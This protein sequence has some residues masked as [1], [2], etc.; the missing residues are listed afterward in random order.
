MK[1]TQASASPRPALGLI[2]AVAV[3]VGIVIGAGIFETPSLVAANSSSAGQLLFFWILGGLISLIGA[4]CYAEL[5]TAYPNAGG[6]YFYLKHGLGRN[7]GFLFAWA[8]MLVIQTGSISLLAF[9]F[10][11]YISQI[12]SLG[13]HSSSIYAAMVIVFFT[14][15]NVIGIQ[16]GKRAQNILSAAQIIGLLAL[17]FMGFYFSNGAVSEASVVKARTSN[18]GLAM[19]FVLLSFGG[20]NEAAFISAEIHNKN[21]NIIRSLLLSLGIIT[22][23]YALVN[24]AI[25]RGLGLEKMAESQAVA[26]TLMQQ[27]SGAKGAVFI[28]ILITICALGSINATILTGA[29]SNYALGKDF[30]LFAFLGHWQLRSSAPVSAYLFQAAIA[31]LLVL[32]GSFT[33]HGFETMVEYTAPVFWFFFLLSGVALIVL[34]CKEPKLERPFK[35]P[36]YPLT[37]ILFCVFCAYLLYSSLVYTGIGATVGVLV[38]ALGVPFLFWDYR[39]AKNLNKSKSI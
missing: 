31:L 17:V 27:I 36:L 11:D 24:L 3:I 5:A 1:E 15:L 21:K 39:Q 20:W 16:Q 12:W 34:R 35:V 23:V 26:A 33:R 13:Q 18:M 37:P 28:S 14:A 19:V 38:V 32:L 4:L 2:D 8:R 6:T 29:R 25:L 7:I 30:K 10:G 22:L 9:V